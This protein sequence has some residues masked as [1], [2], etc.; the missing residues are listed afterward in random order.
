MKVKELI[1]KLE[2]VDPESVVAISV[3][4]IYIPNAREVDAYS[5]NVDLDV[6]WGKKTVVLIGKED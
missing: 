3:E 1:E 6:N 2:K 5:E 4:G